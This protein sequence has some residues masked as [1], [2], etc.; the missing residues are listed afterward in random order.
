MCTSFYFL[1]WAWDQ[2]VLMWLHDVLESYLEHLL[3]LTD[4]HLPALLFP[5]S[6]PLCL[7]P[8]LLTAVTTPPIPL[9]LYPCPPSFI[10]PW[11]SRSSLLFSLTSVPLCPRVPVFLLISLCF[12]PSTT[13]SPSPPKPHFVP[14]APSISLLSPLCVLIPPH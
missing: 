1:S 10:L 6:L 7:F 8:P 14:P 12:V 13:P 2:P 5:S 4:R 11:A 9:T 3:L